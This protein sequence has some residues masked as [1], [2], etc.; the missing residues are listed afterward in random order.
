MT[1]YRC[2]HWRSIEEHFIVHRWMC[3]FA[4]FGI[5]CS[6]KSVLYIYV[7]VAMS[8]SFLSRPIFG[9]HC[10]RLLLLWH[11]ASCIHFTEAKIVTSS[12]FDCVSSKIETNFLHLFFQIA[13]AVP[14]HLPRF[15]HF[16]SKQRQNTLIRCMQTGKLPVNV[17]SNRQTN[18]IHQLTECFYST[19]KSICTKSEQ[20]VKTCSL[21]WLLHWKSI[22]QKLCVATHCL[23]C[24][25]THV[26]LCSIIIYSYVHFSSLRWWWIMFPMQQLPVDFALIC[27]IFW[28]IFESKWTGFES[29]S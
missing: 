10:W 7:N 8:F 18:F 17:Y 27:S 23:L 24:V 2:A 21:L 29:L 20:C 11:Y 1:A 16:N 25:C 5:V 14:H 19:N 26:L 15:Y 12:S 6:S 13:L 22:Q 3:E 4:H 28:L 9:S